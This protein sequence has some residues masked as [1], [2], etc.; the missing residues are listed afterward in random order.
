M[1]KAVLGR[2]KGLSWRI[3]FS[4]IALTCFSLTTLSSASLKRGSPADHLPPYIRRLTYFGERADWS[5]DGKR[6]LFIARTFGDVYE[7]E[8][9]TGII[10]PVTHHYFHEGYTRALYLTNGDILLSGAPEFDARNPWPS[11]TSKAELWILDKSLT[12]PPVR[13]GEKCSEGPAVSRKRM[14]IAWTIDHDDYPDRIPEGVSQIWMADI[15]YSRGM[16]HLVNKRLVLDSRDLPFRCS[17]ETQNFR[18]PE[19][20]ELIFS[21]YGY[22]GT[23]VCGINLET[24]KVVNYSKAPGQYDEPEGIFPDGKY[25]C[26]ECDRQNRKGPQYID[27]WKLRLDGS[28]HLERLTYFSDYEGYKASNPVISDDGCFMAFQMAKTGDPAGFGRGIFLFDLKHF[29]EI[30]QRKKLKYQ[31]KRGQR[32]FYRSTAARMKVFSFRLSAIFCEGT[33]GRADDA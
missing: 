18:P 21:A 16:P 2:R 6:I 12:K 1:L 31:V 3:I 25:T 24:K 20:K 23:E 17:L 14:R 4:S 10:R 26:V 33:G 19:E 11:R 13:L 28:G 22:Q 7:Y 15:R 30:Q 5:H 9:A 29:E 32:G 27:I 8:L